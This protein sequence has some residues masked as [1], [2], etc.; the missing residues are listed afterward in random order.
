MVMHDAMGNIDASKS[1]NTLIFILEMRL[2]L[3]IDSPYNERSD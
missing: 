3:F 1:N 2:T